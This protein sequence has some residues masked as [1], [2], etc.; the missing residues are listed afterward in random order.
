M[1]IMYLRKVSRR[2]TDNSTVSY[3]QIAENIWDKHKRRSHVRVLCT[4]GRAD[5]KAVDHLRQ[6]VASIHRQAPESGVKLEDG[7]KFENS[8]DHGAFY[9]VGRLWEQ[10]GIR[11][12]VEAA[13]K[14]EERK[15]PLERAVFT[16]VAN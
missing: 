12:I 11:R 16:M 7:W 14:G 15:T 6:L 13:A 10:L 1:D 8:W 2:N 4:L 5:E 3:L 9:V